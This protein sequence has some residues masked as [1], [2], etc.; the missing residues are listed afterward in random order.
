MKIRAS[1][2]ALLYSLLSCDSICRNQVSFCSPL[3]STGY[4]YENCLQWIVVSSEE[5]LLL[6]LSYWCSRGL[7]IFPRVRGE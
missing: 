5:I 4:G 7:L 6:V 2:D 1:F 3:C